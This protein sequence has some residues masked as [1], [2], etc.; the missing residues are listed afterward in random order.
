[1][2]NLQTEEQVMAKFIYE[3][4]A[5]EDDPV[6]QEPWTVSTTRRKMEKAT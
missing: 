2:E 4:L 1:M 6:Y 3:G 5:P